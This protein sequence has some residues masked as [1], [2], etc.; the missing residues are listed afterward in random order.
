[1]I[2]RVCEVAIPRPFLGTLA[3]S[4]PEG[5]IERVR[6]GVRV[7]VPLGKRGT[8][9]VVDRLGL[10]DQ[11]SEEPGR[12]R[13][14]GDVLDDSEVADPQLLELCR[15][16]ADYYVA[17]LGVILK[18][19]LP[20]GLL[21]GRAGTSEPA[22]RTERIV[23]IVRRLE[24][25][26][27][28]DET[29]GRAARQREAY[30]TL[31]SLDGEAALAH[32][33]GHLG[34]S[35]SVID[36]LT[37]RGLVELADRTVER[38]PFAGA[39]ATRDLI[40]PTADQARVLD[41]LREMAGS[42]VGSVA[43]LRG[44][45]GSG[46]TLVYLELLESVL[47]AGRSGIV[48]VP[49]ISLTPQTVARFRGRFGDD[50][51]VLHSGLSDGERYDAWRALREGRKRIA[52]GPRSAVFAPLRDLG[53]VV[54]DEEHESSYKQ[55]DTPRYHARS[56]AIVR[57]R[58]AGC[59]CLLG[60]A[61]PSLESWHNGRAGRY[62]VLELEERVTG[63]GLPTVRLIDLKT[64]REA[65]AGDASDDATRGER[66][67]LI[68]SPELSEAITARLARG[69]QSILLLNRRGYA[70]FVECLD[71]GRVWSCRN[72]SV[73]L[74]FHRRRARLVC[75]HCG[76]E[77][78]PPASCDE[79]G[80][81]EPRFTGVGTEQVERR[82][83]EL[84]PEARLAR[85]DLDT[86]GTKWAHVEILDAFRDR[87]IDILLGTQMIAKGL[88]F[89]GVTLVG[90]INADVG[91][92]IPDFRAT[93]RTFQLLEQ[94]AGRAG[95]GADPGEV[96]VQTSRPRH[97]ALARAAEH[98]YVGFAER[99]LADR[100]EPVYPPHVRLANLVVSGLREDRVAD[101]AD[102]LAEWTRA[103]ID[104]RELDGIEVIGPAP[105]AID[106]LRDRW[107]W[108]LLIKSRHA[109]EL[110][111]VLRFLANRRARVDSELRVEIDRDP[112]SLL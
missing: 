71:C 7:R 44:V 63:H 6:P 48:L 95:R 10:S 46:K 59:L 72:C 40:V 66:G 109:A 88:D 4:I 92:H 105:C 56:V 100:E 55:S 22:V 103:L 41:S 8:V 68:V 3:Y 96:L 57:A 16:I 13:P 78:A 34:F 27:D 26:I 91:L 67:P 79:C 39:P 35:R 1:M 77:M 106:R 36:G 82:L 52:I 54:V 23:R 97:F 18:T 69:E 60:S 84:F 43:L 73:T 111:A 45:T 15:W 62:R 20:P 64:A 5:L 32:L 112:E 2:D 19:A 9:G 65:G 49:E 29:F 87:E 24:T 86:T 28:R 31:E 70:T 47:A 94:V 76:F 12:L 38:D 107:R 14:V 83:A 21:G 33:T 61:T 81:P 99:E 85:M 25:L 108:H 11:R 102:S 42:G 98:D 75:H 93:E 53:L 74:T 110:G 58:L 89:P 50:V 101:E 51:A 104:D 30:E 90:V 37:G 80:A 17:P